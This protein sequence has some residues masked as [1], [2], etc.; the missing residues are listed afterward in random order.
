MG[1]NDNFGEDGSFLKKGS[2]IHLR[3]Y[4]GRFLRLLRKTK[5]V[6]LRAE[7]ENRRYLEYE[8]AG[9]TT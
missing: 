2:S 3:V 7:N 8:T 1:R 4:S 6:D 5:E 9:I